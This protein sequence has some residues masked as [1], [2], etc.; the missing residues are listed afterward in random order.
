[1][2]VALRVRNE[3]PGVVTIGSSTSE[4][5]RNA[6]IEPKSKTGVVVGAYFDGSTF[7][8]GKV[9]GEHLQTRH[10]ATIAT[11]APADVILEEMLDLIGRTMD[12]DVEGIGFGVP[13]VVDVEHGIVFET[14]N[15]PS[16]KRVNV[17]Q[18]VESRFGVP[19]QVNNEANAFT[20][21]EKYFGAGKGRRNLVGVI[22]GTGL[23]AGVIFDGR[24]C[25][26]A[27][28]GAGEIGH[29]P[30]L[31]GEV[32]DYCSRK[33]FA[34]E[35]PQTNE[36]FL[37]GRA[38]RGDAD[39]VKLF[40]RFGRHLGKAMLTVLYCFDP[41][42]VVFGGPLADAFPYFESGM[43][44]ELRA[45]TFRH[46]LQKLEIVPSARATGGI[47]GAAAIYLDMQSS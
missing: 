6:A 16:W 1:M 46:S 3:P 14:H 32:E 26:G 47:R 42:I 43:R 15:V 36:V 8:V 21:G 18:A 34:R 37:M 31:D 29:I 11:D 10:F 45:F 35:A 28:C 17:K 41:E 20:V 38:K 40:E 44:Q 5:R 39:V 19:C 2:S 13:S 33:F 9:R 30:Y 12:D 23:G 24:L 7:R 22:L 25:N 4:R 27:N